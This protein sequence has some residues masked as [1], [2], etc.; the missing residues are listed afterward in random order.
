MDPPLNDVIAVVTRKAAPP[1]RVTVTPP[2]LPTSPAGRQI[3]LA[4]NGNDNEKSTV[5]ATVTLGA[6]N[7]IGMSTTCSAPTCTGTVLL[8]KGGAGAN[9]SVYV[10]GGR[11]L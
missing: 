7:T 6:T 1:S 11:L 4:P 10:P 5:P 3:L 2:H 9:V 8:R